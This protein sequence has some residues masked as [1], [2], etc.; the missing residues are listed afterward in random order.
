MPLSD[1]SRWSSFLGSHHTTYSFQARGFYEKLGYRLAGQID[2][3]PPG[4]SYYWLR[5]G[6]SV[7]GEA[8]SAQ[9][10]L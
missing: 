3:Y 10:S 2:D 9:E 6:F 7:E 5:K 8:V 4:R 1:G